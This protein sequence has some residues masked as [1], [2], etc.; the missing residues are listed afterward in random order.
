MYRRKGRILAGILAMVLVCTSSGVSALADETENPTYAYEDSASGTDTAGGSG[1]AELEKDTVPTDGEPDD[2]DAPGKDGETSRKDEE[3]SGEDQELSGEESGT[4][5]EEEDISSEEENDVRAEVPENVPENEETADE[6]AEEAVEKVITSWSWED[7]KGALQETGSGWSLV[8]LGA[9]KENPPTREQIEAALPTQILASVEGVS[10]KVTLDLTWDLS[11]IQ[12]G[13][14]TEDSI[15]VSAEVEAEDGVTYK[16]KEDIARLNVKV[17]AGLPETTGASEENLQAN[18]VMGVSPN[19]TTINVFDYWLTEQD[20]PDGQRYP[21]WEECF[22][23]GINAGHVLKFSKD[24]GTDK[25]ETSVENPPTSYLANVWTGKTVLAGN[26]TGPGM[27]RG[28][29][30][31]AELGEDGY[32]VLNVSDGEKESLAYLFSPQVSSAYKA[33]Y[34]DAKGLL[35]I[36]ADGYYYYDSHKNFAEFDT[37]S[38]EFTLYDT[39]GVEP[40]GTSPQGQFFPFNT[41]AQVFQDNG[42]EIEAKPK[43]SL[44]SR[45]PVI[46]HYFGLTMSTRFVQQYG[47]HT[48]EKDG[49]EVTYTFSGDDDVW[50][51]IDGVLVADLGGIHDE[52]NLEINFAT[53]V[54]KVNGV[55]TNTLGKIFNTGSATLPDNTYHTLDFF[56]LERGNTDSNM[57][58]K[59]NL[60]T[61]PES[62]VI[63]VDQTG[64]PVP[65]AEFKLYSANDTNKSDPI[66][67]GTTGRDGEFVFLGD[68]DLPITIEQLYESY[69]D[70]G[71]D[72][73]DPDLILSETYVPAGYRS[74]GD[75]ELR[76][77]ENKA[78]EEVMLLA[79]NQWEVGAY[80]MPKVMVTAPNVIV[81][82]DKNNRATLDPKDNPLVFAV[83]FQKQDDDTWQPIYG[84]PLNGW[85]LTEEKDEWAAIRKA[86]EADPYIFQ[87]ASS[88]AYQTEI[89]NLPGD[90]QD[91]YHICGDESQAKYTVGYYYSTADSLSKVTAKNTWRINAELEESTGSN[92]DRIFSV[93]LYVPNIKNRLFVQKVDDIGNPLKDVGF[94]LYKADQVTVAGDGTVTLNQNAEVYDSLKTTTIGEPLNLEGGGMFPT[95]QK[96]ILEIGEYYL[97]ETKGLEGYVKNETPVHIIVDDTGVY[98]D[99]GNEKDGVSVLKGV[100]SIVKSMVQFAADDNVDTTLNG[101][102]A[103]LESGTYNNGKFT[104]TDNWNENADILHLQY[105][106]KNAVLD[107]GLT[108]GKEG[109]LESLTRATDIGWSRLAIRQCFV[110]DNS[111]DTSL[112]TN[113]KDMDITKLFSGTTIVRV[114]NERTGSLKIT[115]Q[116]VNQPDPSKNDVFEFTLTGVDRDGN[117]L[118]GT[119][120]YEG[121][122]SPSE[123]QVTFKDGTA[124]VLLTGGQSITIKGLPLG[125]E[126]TV[127]E[128]HP[129]TEYEVSYQVGEGKVTS[130]DTAEDVKIPDGEKTEVEVTFTNT[131]ASETDFVFKKTDRGGSPV[132]DARFAIYRLVCT[133]SSHDHSEDLIE[134]GEDGSL[135]TGYEYKDCW[136]LAAGPVT[137]GAQGLVSFTGIKVFEGAQYRLVEV[138]TPDGYVEPGGQWVLNCVDGELQFASGDGASVGNPPAVEK[139][140][141]GETYYSIINYKPGELPFSG[142]TGIRLFLMIGGALMAFGAAGGGWYLYRRKAAAVRGSRG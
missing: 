93:N 31:Q 83:I 125:A 57:S 35:Q 65:G 130:G 86:A 2:Q 70:V 17:T 131:Y 76:F 37:E 84:D 19:G 11:A 68:N 62:S 30:V 132:K 134:A 90:I 74:N 82:V 135:E 120:D 45:S 33:S 5:R 121:T 94:A 56:Y 107:Y 85:H 42:N 47:G 119:Y 53:G 21:D 136:E 16:L 50:I 66:A 117:K 9:S 118:S 25:T 100:G 116:V 109:T 87:L 23:V 27:P 96:G 13:S 58:L 92:F 8:V 6:T 32:P 101:I 38:K 15:T 18:T 141:P 77:Y 28:G 49:K 10:G 51:F 128:K 20:E 105:A 7:T 127:K 104:W 137:S 48:K 103:V 55:E 69:G 79:C 67:T 110:H 61:I 22:E 59:Y 102:K 78:D 140:G 44:N 111:T 1:T 112:K 88:G 60:V 36:D 115:K 81:G 75:L 142:N 139:P 124:S 24:R 52:S 12:E 43:A 99:A 123:G 122:G 63:K 46:N 126:I 138:K 39:W 80:A 98:A 91:Y 14:W 97:F 71:E 26:K 64:D 95:S 29:I 41:G 72:E 114:E 34:T 3:I 129:D 73:G 4:F 133:D 108:N 106:N 40:G 54:I 89:E 113:L